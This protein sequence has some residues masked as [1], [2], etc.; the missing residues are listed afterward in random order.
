MAE[1][2]ERELKKCR[3]CGLVKPVSEFWR[4]KQSPD[5]WAL[6]CKVCFR[7]RNAASYRG[8]LAVQGKKARPYRSHS[9]VPPGMKYCA[10]CGETKPVSE[11]GQNRAN[12]SGLAYYCKPCHNKVMAANKQKIHGS[13]RSYHLKRRYGLTAE[14]VAERQMLQLRRCLIC[15]KEAA[16]HV[17]HDHA[18]G[19]LRGL[20]CFSCN[21]GLGQFKDDPD[22]LRKAADY[23]EGTDFVDG[24][25]VLKITAAGE[26]TAERPSAEQRLRRHYK[27]SARYGIGLDEV[28]RMI[29]EQGGVCAICRS[30]APRDV[31]HDH[32]T[33]EVRGILCSP[34][35]TGM[36]LFKDDAHH[37]RDAATYL[38]GTAADPELYQWSRFVRVVVGHAPGLRPQR[39]RLEELMAEMV[40]EFGAN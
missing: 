13:T 26:A 8:R 31:D 39:S 28:E 29:E 20:L 17:D 40:R 12:K 19:N 24:P 23:L 14:D 5:G 22:T 16:L 36:G 18:C 37:L 21:N 10:N 32:E 30:A 35:N 34:C 3:D 33:G 7:L 6:Y 11:F 4:R 9:D 38:E 27:L 1:S 25:I 15:L 2:S